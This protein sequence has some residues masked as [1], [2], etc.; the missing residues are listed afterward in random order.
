M[1]RSTFPLLRRHVAAKYALICLSL[2]VTVLGAQICTA[3]QEIAIE[4]STPKAGQYE[5]VEFSID[6]NRQ[7]ENPF[8]PSQADL[9]VVFETP[10]GGRLRVPAFYC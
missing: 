7:Y 2:L 1:Y 8:D 3:Q 10:S 9:G 6:C 4:A 5:K